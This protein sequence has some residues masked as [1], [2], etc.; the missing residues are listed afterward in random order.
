MARRRPR[1][2][3]KQRSRTVA[4]RV[5][6]AF[7]AAGALWILTTDILLY[8]FVTD[9]VVIGRIETAKGWTMVALSAAFLF[10]VV[11]RSVRQLARSDATLHAVVDSIADGVFI[12]RPDRSVGSVNHAAACMLGVEPEQ[13]V[14]MRAD[15]FVRRYNISRPDGHLVAADELISQRALSGEQPPSYKA[16][17]RPP[18]RDEIVAICTS[19]PV[20]PFPGGGVELAVTV[21]HDI[22]KLDHLHRMREQFVS[23]AAHEL[24]TPVT[25]IS[26]C[27]HL[28]AMANNARPDVTQMIERQCGRIVRLTDNLIVLARIRSDSLTFHLEPVACAELVE[29]VTREM[30]HAT[31]DH[32][33]VSCVEARPT[34]FADRERVGLLIKNL[35]DLAFYR[36]WPRTQITVG[37]SESENRAR[38]RVTYEPRGVEDEGAHQGLGI[39]SHVIESVAHE[40]RGTVGALQMGRSLRSEWIDFPTMVQN[41]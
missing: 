19:A 36:S 22:T 3:M 6:F 28:L 17:I 24:R 9:P 32:G 41:A 16:I 11:D 30:K 29:E 10:W 12:L 40:L 13:L 37:V 15:E 1:D 39:E 18:D 26:A 7:L 25:I 23:A 5:A 33:L 35:I 20:R 21:I 38:I 4:V 14:G 27:M 2:P 34:I 8:R 31:V